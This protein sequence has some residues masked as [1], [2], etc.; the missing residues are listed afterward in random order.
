[1][2]KVT[3]KEENF[4]KEIQNEN[5]KNLNQRKLSVHAP[6]KTTE[7]NTIAPPPQRLSKKKSSKK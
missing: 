7:V 6:E 5:E 1:M 2:K 3:E 4:F